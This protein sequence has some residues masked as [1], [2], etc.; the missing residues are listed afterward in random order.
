M[1]GNVLQHQPFASGVDISFWSSL[2]T[3]KLEE[4][5]LSDTARPAWGSYSTPLPASSAPS[6]ATA[7]VAAG[8]VQ[9]ARLSVFGESFERDGDAPRRAVRA[10]GAVTVVNTA[11]AFKEVNSWN[12]PSC[13]LLCLELCSVSSPHDYAIS[14]ITRHARLQREILK[15]RSR[16]MPPLC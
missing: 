6:S 12:M 10:V 2:S 8:A 3:L 4:L 14:A 15:S 7:P 1:A 13:H 9:P 5:R 11:D 16:D